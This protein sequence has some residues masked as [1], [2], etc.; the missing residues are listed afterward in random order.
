MILLGTSEFKRTH[1]R[2]VGSDVESVAGKWT[3]SPAESAHPL[4]KLKIL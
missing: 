2:I 4:K 1:L 3:L